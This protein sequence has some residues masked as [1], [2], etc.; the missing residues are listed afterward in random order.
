MELTDE[1]RIHHDV[2]RA[3]DVPWDE[4]FQQLKQPLLDGD[5]PPYIFN[6]LEENDHKR[7][8]VQLSL[9][10]EAVRAFHGLLQKFLQ[11][12]GYLGRGRRMSPW[13]ILFSDEG[14][15]RQRAHTDFCP[16]PEIQR[17][18]RG[19]GKM[20]LLVLVA[21]ID[22]TKLD[23]WPGSTGCLHETSTKKLRRQTLELNA[24]DVLVF[25]PDL[26][27]AGSAY[28]TANVRLHCY[29]DATTWRRKSNETFIIRQHADASLRAR[30]KERSS[31]SS[32]SSSSW[33]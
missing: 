18:L 7:L 25:R 14:C 17:A 13:V 16:T 33:F 6:G 20:P 19:E 4:L 10:D 12:E 9:D 5:D 31:S 8:Q 30:T 22:E 2:F 21:L 15:A 29:L 11:R 24:G 27:H 23:I 3:S 32:S 1:Y 28:A 26:I